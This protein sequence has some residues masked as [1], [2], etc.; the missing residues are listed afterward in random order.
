MRRSN[1]KSQTLRMMRWYGPFVP[2]ADSP[3]AGPV[4]YATSSQSHK[5]TDT[6]ALA[7]EI[8]RLTAQGLRARDIASALH[9]HPL[10][11]LRTLESV[12][13]RAA[14]ESTRVKQ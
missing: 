4:A 7:R 3:I 5:P 13:T 2:D 10:I 9:V 14:A 1:S 6:E 11:V 8:D 12:G